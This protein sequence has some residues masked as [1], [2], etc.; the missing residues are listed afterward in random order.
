MREKGPQAAGHALREL[1]VKDLG[2]MPYA[3][4]L[5]LQRTVAAARI[6]GSVPQDVVLLV[7]HPPV[8]TLGRSAKALA[9]AVQPASVL[10]VE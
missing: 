8:I 4:A 1:W 10:L 6:A 5:E 9:I 2:L 3:G 7:E